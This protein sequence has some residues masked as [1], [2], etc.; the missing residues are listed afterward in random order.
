M[1]SNVPVMPR[2]MYQRFGRILT[3]PLCRNYRCVNPKTLA[4]HEKMH[5]AGERAQSAVGYKCSFC[6]M[7]KLTEVDMQEHCARAHSIEAT[8]SAAAGTDEIPCIKVESD[9]ELEEQ[10]QTDPPMQPIIKGEREDEELQRLHVEE[11]QADPH[12]HTIF[13]E[14]PE[15]RQL[16]VEEQQRLPEQERQAD[17]H[18]VPVKEEPGQEEGHPGQVEEQQEEGE[19]A[20]EVNPLVNSLAR[21]G[22]L[23]RPLASPE[24]TFMIL[25]V[26]RKVRKDRNLL[27][28]GVKGVRRM[29][30]QGE[31]QFVVLTA[32]AKPQFRLLELIRLCKKSCVP[33]VFI[34]YRHAL[35]WAC[36]TRG[37]NGVLV[38]AFTADMH[39]QGPIVRSQIE[40]VKR[41]IKCLHK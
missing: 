22:P 17:P 9:E 40:F 4:R 19:N 2:Q 30:S 7:F 20:V 16:P 35:R 1:N 12:E 32:D 21:A 29:L 41:A 3:C 5:M 28:K 11:Q 38:A 14:E 24:L 26:A 36:S 15:Q 8:C 23:A 10:E 33:Y 18:E 39:G 25:Y 34:K 31:I 27:M 37:K 6:N 13:E